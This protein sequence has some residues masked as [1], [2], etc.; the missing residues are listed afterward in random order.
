[1][2]EPKYKF[3]NFDEYCKTCEYELYADYE[4][5][6]CDCLVEATNLYSHRPVY[7]KRDGEKVKAQSERRNNNGNH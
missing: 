1:M 4:I 2:D 7:W 3:V 5:P 6:C